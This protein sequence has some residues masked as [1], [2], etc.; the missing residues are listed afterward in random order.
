M[1]VGEWGLVSGCREGLFSPLFHEPDWCDTHYGKSHRNT[2][3][4]SGRPN[5][6]APEAPH[7]W[8]LGLRPGKVRAKSRTDSVALGWGWYPPPFLKPEQHLSLIGDPL[9]PSSPLCQSLSQW[10]SLKPGKWGRIQGAL[11]G[12]QVHTR[13]QCSWNPALESSLVFPRCSRVQQRQPQTVDHW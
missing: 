5:P 12:M 2:L 11:G 13:A 8:I 1:G 7:I 9:V 4:A 10:L 6:L 3:L